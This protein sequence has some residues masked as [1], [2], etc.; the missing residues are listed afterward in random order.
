MSEVE[1]YQQALKQ[2]ADMITP[3]MAKLPPATKYQ[4]KLT[5]APFIE[6]YKAVYGDSESGAP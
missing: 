5:L 6:A 4:P 2:F 3:A 1:K